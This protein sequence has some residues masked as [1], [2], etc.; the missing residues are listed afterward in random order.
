MV[1]CDDGAVV[2]LNE[3]GTIVQLGQVDGRPTHVKKLDGPGGP[4]VVLATDSGQVKVFTMG[5]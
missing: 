5:D 3:R 2:V 4:L 1:G